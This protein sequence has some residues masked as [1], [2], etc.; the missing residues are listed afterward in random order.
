MV[1]NVLPIDPDNR[2]EERCSRSQILLK[3]SMI[4]R[5]G[6][7]QAHIQAIGDDFEFVAPATSC[8][9]GDYEAKSRQP[10]RTVDR[11]KR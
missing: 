3:I 1:G 10:M 5:F 2:K 8:V 9:S 7:A 4:W 6:F 11:R